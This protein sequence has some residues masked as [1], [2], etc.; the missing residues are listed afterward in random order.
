LA[1]IRTI[2]PDFWTNEKVLGIS[3]LTR[4]LFIGMWNFADDYGRLAF[5]PISIKAKIF[6]N[7]AISDTDVRDMLHE[8]SRADLLMIYSAKDKEYIEITGWDH[9]RIDKRQ[10]SKIPAPFAEGSV[11]RGIPPTSPDLPQPPPTPAPVREGKGREGKVDSEAN[12]SGADAPPDPA[13]PER[14]YFMRGRE[15]LGNKSG[16]MIANL[17]KAKGKNVAL[18]RAA[19][20]EASQKQSPI[21][22]VAA[23]CRGPPMSAKPLTEFQRKQQETN[24]VRAQLRNYANGGGRGGNADRVLSD[25]TGKRPEDL[26]GGPGATVLA[27]PRASGSGGD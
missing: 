13:V 5:S 8:L 27:L 9:Q 19:L 1:R 18:A 25:D 6:A 16:A 15:V 22:Y 3:P 26:R 23:I 12:A 20:E 4:L 2:K 7:D 17:L 11:I 24:D 14:D 10:A 21:E